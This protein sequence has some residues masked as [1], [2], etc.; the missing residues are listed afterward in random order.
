MMNIFLK[1]MVIQL[2]NILKKVLMLS[3]IKIT[4][5]GPRLHDLRHTYL[6]HNID[7]KAY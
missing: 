5:K 2:Q 7:I 1:Y 4:D 6:V 3:N